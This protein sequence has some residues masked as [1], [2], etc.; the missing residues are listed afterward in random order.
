[1]NFTLFASQREHWIKI[2]H[3]FPETLIWVIF[4]DTPYEVCS[5]RLQ[6]RTSHPTIH[7]PELGLS[8]LSRFARDFRAPSAHEGFHRMI[9]LKP[10]D[11]KPD[12]LASDISSI[13]DRVRSSEPVLHIPEPVRNSWARKLKARHTSQPNG[14]Q[15]HSISTT[16]GNNNNNGIWERFGRRTTPT[17]STIANTSVSSPSD[18][19]HEDPVAQEERVNVQYPPLRDSLGIN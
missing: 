12:Y 18:D 7:S 19:I 17:H 2:A 11:T 15:S 8:I 1:M 10:P 14:N 4:F 9:S 16:D 5:S 6:Q 3:E 13:L